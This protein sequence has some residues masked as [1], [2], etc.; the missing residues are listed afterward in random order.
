MNTNIEASLEAVENLEAGD[1]IRSLDVGSDAFNAAVKDLTKG[2]KAETNGEDEDTPAG[3]EEDD[4]VDGSDEDP[5]D[6]ADTDEDDDE[7]AHGNPRS[8]T[9]KLLKYKREA[10]EAK[11]KLAKYEQAE[12][13]KSEPA[14][15]KLGSAP[16]KLEDCAT[17]ADWQ[18]KM[19]DH[20]FEQRELERDAKAEHAKI[21][22]IWDDNEAQVKESASDYSKVTDTAK[23]KKAGVLD[24]DVLHTLTLFDNGPA[25]LY[26]LMKD[27]ELLAKFTAGSTHR[28]IAILGQVDARLDESTEMKPASTRVSSTPPPKFPKGYAKTKMDPIVDVLKM[29][30]AT[31]FRRMDEIDRDK[32]RR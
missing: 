4:V 31:W 14:K 16:P 27:P 28:K 2:S 25:V 9:A 26:N 13:K 22:K 30:D 18:S 5:E 15:P 32:R 29:D 3:I 6:D 17:Y 10:K 12:T 11:E 19:V 21:G 20:K 23:L 24:N 7:P 8:A 1:P